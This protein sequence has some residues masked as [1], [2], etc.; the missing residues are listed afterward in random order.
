M[1]LL[2]PS[3]CCSAA[4]PGRRTS[5]WARRSPTA[6]GREVEP[7]IGF[8]MNTLVLRADLAG[9]P[10]FRELL[11][12]CARRRSAPTRTRSSPSSGW[13]RS[14]TRRA[15]YRA[16]PWC[17][18][19]FNL[20]LPPPE[21][22]A[23]QL[24]AGGR[25]ALPPDPGA[26]FDFTLYVNEGRRRLGLRSVYNRELFDAARMQELLA[27]TSGCSRRSSADPDQRGH[28]ALAADGAE[29]LLPDP[30]A[31]LDAAWAARSRAGSPRRRAAP[32]AGGR[33][34]TS[35]SAGATPSWRRRAAAWPT[36]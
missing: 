27:S 35:G 26:K 4:S 23:T 32:R 5:R 34:R 18:V 31:P 33:C 16:R 22:E 29:A 28:A 10:S 36:G 15:I 17:Q 24:R 21:R 3:S 14:S 6:R 11:G 19:L 12:G 30:A 7:L 2:A 8:F 9:D 20:M 13:S 25:A 1:T